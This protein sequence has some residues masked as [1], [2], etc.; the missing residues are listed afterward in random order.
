[1]KKTENGR[2]E[3]AEKMEV[4]GQV[5][6]IDGMS[7]LLSKY[8]AG[9]NM[10]KFNA[11]T[12]QVSALLL[13]ENKALADRIIAMGREIGEEEVQAL[14]DGAYAAALRD[15]IVRDVMGFFASSA[16]TAGQK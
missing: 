9:M 12:I 3:L 4:I 15:A 5:F 13:R 10:V 6:E 2:N 8:E 11:V 14:E 7:D 1:M 16:P